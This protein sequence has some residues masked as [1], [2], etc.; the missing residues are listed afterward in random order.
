[1]LLAGGDCDLRAVGQLQR[2]RKLAA[3]QGP[4]VGRHIKS[5]VILAVSMYAS[6]LQSRDGKLIATFDSQ[7]AI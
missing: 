4:Q 6:T 2:I 1:M 5:L 3:I 7:S